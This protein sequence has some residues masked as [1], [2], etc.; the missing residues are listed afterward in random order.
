MSVEMPP[1][2][3]PRGPN[4]TR[5][6]G[7]TSH[8]RAGDATKWISQ[9]PPRQSATSHA[10]VVGVTPRGS[11]KRR[12]LPSSTPNPHSLSHEAE[13]LAT[14]AVAAHRKSALESSI[15]PHL[16]ASSSPKVVPLFYLCRFD[17]FL[18]FLSILDIV[19]IDSF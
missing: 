11:K 18:D 17:F 16:H 19:E 8:V 2:V 14:A 10:K 7:A 4:H 6:G 9:K 13:D 1:D 5:A 3:V 15:P 12:S